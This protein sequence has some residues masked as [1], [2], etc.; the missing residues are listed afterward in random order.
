MKRALKIFA[1]TLGGIIVTV[2]AVVC[3]AMYLIF[4][5]E[6]LTPIARQLADKYVVCD[7]EIGEVD[8]TFFSTFPYFGASVKDV[9]IIN[10]VTGAQSDTV[11]AVPELVVSLKILDA[12]NGDIYIQKCRLNDAK[13]NIYIASDGLTNFDVLALPQSEETPEDTT[14]GWQLKS[15]AWDDAIT[16]K[17]SNLSFV[18]EKDTISASLQNA[19]ISLEAIRKNDM[20]G[21]RLDLQAEHICGLSKAKHMLTTCV[22]GC[23]YQLSWRKVPNGSSSMVQSCRSM[24]SI[25]PWTAR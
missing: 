14:A 3:I 4:T 2:V 11:L 25:S 6:R 19:S 16:I 13:A 20:D 22:S 5:P 23:T 24:S 18:D 21:A 17:A 9:L 1:W 7:H 8:L 10:P 15:L 12:I